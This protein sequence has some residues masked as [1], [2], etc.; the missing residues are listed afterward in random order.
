MDHP[1]GPLP[2]PP[3]GRRGPHKGSPPARGPLAGSVRAFAGG[4]AEGA[5]APPSLAE[6]QL[7]R[8]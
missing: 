7:L 4:E 5:R 6:L 8:I 2:R 1:G 3:L